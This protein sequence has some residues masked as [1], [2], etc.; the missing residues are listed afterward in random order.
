MTLFKKIISCSL[1]WFSVLTNL[2]AQ[3]LLDYGNSL[4]YANY[5]FSTR[6]YDLSSIEFER[7]VFMEPTDTLAKLKLIKSYRYSGKIETARERLSAFFPGYPDLLPGDFSVEFLKLS[8]SANNYREG[9]DFLLNNKTI[10]DE[11]RAEYHLGILAAQNRWTEAKSFADRYR[12]LMDKSEKFHSLNEIC[13]NGLNTRYRKPWLAASLS[14]VIP[15]TGKIYS[16]NWKDAVFSFL[17]IT[18]TSWLAYNSIH[19]NG[20]NLESVLIGSAAL[21]FY[22]ANVYGS[23][24]SAS[25]YNQSINQSFRNQVH[26][27]LVDDQ[28]KK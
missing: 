26:D 22:S 13:V 14:A 21:G 27:I 15:G 12:Y 18:G 20:F 4:K 3:D 1:I 6:Q 2:S 19:N 17:L 5:L 10:P 28:E 9:Y 8:F 25:H 7:V 16:G 24:K 23:Y 11:T